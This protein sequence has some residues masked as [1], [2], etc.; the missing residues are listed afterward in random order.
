M[1]W[2]RPLATPRRRS[3]AQGCSAMGAPELSAQRANC[4]QHALASRIC[5]GGYGDLL[6]RHLVLSSIWHFAEDIPTT[7]SCALEG[8][9]VAIGT[10]ALVTSRTSQATQCLKPSSRGRA[11]GALPPEARFGWQ[12]MFCGRFAGVAKHN[13]QRLVSTSLRAACRARNCTRP[14]QTGY[15]PAR[16]PLSDL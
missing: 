3:G 10:A 16:L 12:D 1:K 7:H 15:H 9:K 5:E 4:V 2:K 11:R 14:L 13:R 8:D 6:R